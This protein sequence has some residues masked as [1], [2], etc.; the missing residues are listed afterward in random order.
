RAPRLPGVTFEVRPPPLADR[1]PRMDV[2]VFVGFAAAGP[3]HR[4]VAIE[5][6]GQFA[7]IF[8]DDRAIAW[9]SERGEAVRAHLGPAVRTFF[10]NG[11]RRCWVVRVA[12]EAKT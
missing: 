9:D 8:G 4:P 11:G 5:D 3:L 6:P 10:R 12:G 2:G 1:L 7:A